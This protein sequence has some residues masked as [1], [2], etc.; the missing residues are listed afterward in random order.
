MRKSALRGS[1]MAAALLIA[2]VAA[3]AQTPSP[4]TVESNRPAGTAAQNAPRTIE[5]WRR[6]IDEIDLELVKLLNERAKCAIEIG[7]LKK[8]QG[9]AISAP[10]R[11]AQ[12]L[13]NVTAANRGP[14]EAEAIRRLFERV[15]EEVRRTEKIESEKK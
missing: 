12:V 5:D 13:A 1:L 14:L 3:R 2:A 11:E 6:R 8:Q 4:K 7:Q 15:I 10:Q 9:L